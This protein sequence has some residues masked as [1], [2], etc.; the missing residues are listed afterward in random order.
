MARLIFISPYLKGGQEKAALS[1]RTRYIATREGVE[2]LLEERSDEPATEKQRAL[3]L[4]MLES[5]PQMMELG[6]YA[7]YTAAQTMKNASELIDRAWEQFVSAMGQRENYI[8]Y[9]SHRP[10][11]QKDGEH[12]LWDRNG[13]VQNLQKAVEEVAGHEGTVFTPVISIRREDAERLGYTNAENW[14]AL[15]NACTNALAEGYKIPPKN[16]RWYAA[17]HEKEKHVHIHMIVFSS[18][19]K[20]GYLTKDGIR[21]IKSAF[22]SRIFEQ[23]LEQVYERKTEY[24]DELQRS[25]QEKMTEL[26]L[27]MEHGTI[28]N[29]RIE[30]LTEELAERLRHTK[31]R[32]V[33]GYLPPQLKRI[34]DEIVDELSRDER[35][36]AAYALWQ[37]MQD[38]VCRTYSDTLPERVPLSKQREFK[39]VRNMVIREALSY[40]QQTHEQDEVEYVEPEEETAEE[41]ET[42]STDDS[43]PK[44]PPVKKP[45][46]QP[47]KNPTPTGKSG[48]GEIK[49]VGA[50]VIRMLHHMGRIF[51]DNASEDAFHKGVQIDRK[52]RRQ[53]QEKRM[54]MGHKADDHEEQSQTIN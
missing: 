11:V 12:G 2:R 39:T 21:T 28:R 26:I 36:A 35:V 38:E 48:P 16:L 27:Q 13:K 46:K 40:S 53:L 49:P 1:R 50:A 54:A 31:G 9:V 4:R 34:V 30:R 10:G 8:D 43:T 19:P 45:G 52:R 15:V 18:N 7:D 47:S 20:E 51:R 33:Y 44:P 14:R 5:Y 3:I 37:E 22:A 6:E 42:E 29:E 25:A 17:I 41:S 32:K 24:R 23:D